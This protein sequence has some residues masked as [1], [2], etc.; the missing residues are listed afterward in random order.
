M[1][2]RTVLGLVLIL[3]NFGNVAQAATGLT[4]H[5]RILQSN[6]SPLTSANVFF[7]IQIR[8]PGAEDCLLYDESQTLNMSGS[9]GVFVLTIGSGTRVAAGVDGG[10]PMERVFANRGTLTVPTC[11]FGVSYTPNIADG[12]ELVVQFSDNGGPWQALPTQNI[13]FVPMAI[14]AMQVGGYEKD[15]LL[16]VADGTVATE[17]SNANW[18]E[19]WDLITGAS[20]VY[21][22]A[23][24]SNF[25]PTA[26]VDFNGQKIIDLADPTLA[27]DAATKNYSDTKIGGKDIDVSTVTNLAGNGHVL[28]WDQAQNRWE[29]GLPNDSTKL[30]LAGGTMTGPIN[31]GAFSVT[32]VGHVVI[33]DQGTM[34]LGKFS[35]GQEAALLLTPLNNT[36][37]RGRTWFNVDTGKMRYWDGLAAQDVA[38]KD[39]VDTAVA[40]ATD[41]SKLPL[42]GGTMAGN[43]VMGGNSIT[44]LAAPAGANDAVR[45]VYADSNLLGLALAAPG[46]GE[47]LK[48]VRWN[49]AGNAWEYFT[50]FTAADLTQAN[51]LAALTYTPVD[52]A[53]DTMTGLLLLS[54]DPSNAVGAATKQ[55]VDAVATAA[56]G[57]YV[58]IDGTTSLTADWDLNGLTVG[59]TRLITG[60]DTPVV[61]DGAANK[62]YVDARE[63]AAVVAANNYTDTEV[64]TAVA[65]GETYADASSAAAQA[66]AQTY[67]DGKLVTKDLAVPAAAQDGQSIRW[68]DTTG[69][70]EYFTASVSTGTVSTVTSANT[71]IAITNNTTTPEL[72]LNVG[73]GNNQIVKLNG[74]AELPAVSGVNLTAL[75]ASNIASG[76]LADARLSANVALTSYVDAGDLQLVTKDLAIPVAG[77]DGQSIRWN[78]TSGDWEYFTPNSGDGSALTNLDADNIASGTLA[79]ARL[80]ANVAL[81]TYVDAGDLQL[82]TKDLAI[83]VVGQDGQSIRWNNTSGDWEYFTINS[84]DGSALTNLDADNIASGTL[85]D[86]RLS[87]NVALKSY[88]DAGDLQLVTKD[89]AIPAAGQD[90]QSIRWNDTSGDWEYFTASVSTGTVSTV[91][92]AN[93]DATITNNTTTPE[94]TI[95]TG[96]GNNQIVKLNGSAELP[97]VSGVNLTALN[98]SNIASGTLN[99]ARLSAN[100][101]LTSYVDTAEADAVTAANAYSDGKLVSKDLAIPA[102]GQDGQSI[103]WND[104]SGDWEYFTAGTGNGTVSTVTSANADIGITNNTTIPELTLNVGTGNNQIVKLNGSAELPAVSGVNLTNLNASNLASGT[105]P[106]ARLSANVAM[107][108]YVD[109]KLVTKDLAVPAAGQDGQSIRW[110]NTSGDWEYFT[111]GSGSGTVST[112]TSANGDATITNNTTTPEITINTGTGNN[113][114]VKL[115]GSAELPAVSGVNLTALNA[116]NIASGTIADARLSANVALTSYVDAGDLRLV[117]KDLAIPAAGQDGQS[118]RWNDTS[119][120]WEYFTAGTGNGT[121]STVTS[122]NADIG[123]TNNTTIPEL[124]LN[125]GTGN[126]QIVK[127]NGSA[128][129]PA[130]SGV[131]L[132]NLNASNLASGT[133]PDARLSANVALTSYVD[134][135]EADAVTAAN[136]YSDGK[137]VS[138]D[139]AVPAAGQDGQSIRWNNTSGD[140]EYFTA[141][142]GSGT[143]STVTSANGDATITNNT[144]T[145]EITIN[146]G[147]GNNQIVKLNGSAELPAVSGVN[148]TALNASNIASGTLNDARLSAN[149]AL[150]SYVDAGDLQLVT[151]DLAIPAAGQDGQSIRWNDTSGDWEYFTAGTGNGTV[152]TVT[153]ANADIGITNN[154][155][156]PELTL[157]V[158]T[159]NNQIVKLN[160][161]A[162]LPAV[163]GVNLTALNA[164][165]IASGTLADARLS[166]NVALTSYVD[167]KL[168]TKDL[169]VPAAGQDGQSIRWNNTSGD[170]EYFTAGSGSGTVSTVTSANG[171]ATIT[172]NTTT[173]EITINTGTG[174][175]QIVKLDGS[176]RLP[177]VDASQLTA[178][179]A[180]NIASGT[181]ADARLSANV[182]LTSYVDAGDLKLVTKDLAIPAAGQDG[183]SIR[184]NN[185]SG[186]WE[187]FAA[188][189]GNGTVSTVTSANA[190]I[191]ITNNTTIPELTLNV[192]TGNNQIVK[193]NGSAELPAVSGVNLTALNASNIASG[194]IADARLSANVA[195]ASYV[196][197]KLVTK[198]L[199]V[200]AAGQDGQSIRWN[201]TSGDWEYFTAGSGSGTVS[202]VTSANG[203][204][205]ITNN[206]TIPE[207]TINT[208]TG[209]NQIV[210]LNGSAELP[211]VSGVNLTALNASNIASGTLADARLSANVALKSYVDAGDLQL[212][213]KDLAIPAAGQDGQSIRWNNTSGDWEYFAAGTGNGTVSTVTSANADIGITNNTT[214]PELTLNVGTGNNQIVKLNGSAELPAVSGVNLTALNASN[215]AS[216]TIADARLSANVALKTYVDAGDLQLVT[217]D[218][219]VP[220]AGQDGQSIRWNN[221]SGDWEY[222]TAGSGSG[223]VSTVTSANGDATITNNTTIPEITI[224]T[225]TGN[226][227]IV[228]LNGSAELPAVSGVNLTALN[229]SN[230]ASG[231]LADA[232]LSANV[233]LKAYTDANILGLPLAAPAAGQV[234]QSIRWNAGNT[235]WEYYTPTTSIA[236]DSLN[237]T[238]F[239]DTLALDA[240]TSITAPNGQAYALSVVNE[241][242]GNSLFVGDEAAD[243]SPFV[244]DASGNVGI[245][246]ASPSAKLDV[247]SSGAGAVQTLALRA[248]PGSAGAGNY[249]SIVFD[250][251]FGA[252]NKKNQFVLASNGAAQFALG[253][254]VSGNGGDNFFLWHAATATHPLYV[255]STGNVGIGSTSANAKLDVKG[256]LG[257][258]GST[259]GIVTFAAPATV[260]SGTYVWPAAMPGS[261]MVLQSDNTGA[262]SW[263]AAAASGLPAADGSAGTPGINFTSD[264]NTGIYR[265]G[266]DSMGFSTGGSQ[267]LLIDDNSVVASVGYQNGLVVNSGGAGYG[268]VA[269]TSPNGEGGRIRFADGQ[270]SFAWDT[271]ISRPSAGKLL[272]DNNAGGAATLEVKGTMSIAGTTSGAVQFAVPAVAGSATY[273]WP[274]AAPGSNMILQSDNTGTLSWVA[275]GAAIADDS[276]DFAKF[277]DAMTLDATTTIT[278]PSG[279]A[280]SMLISNEGTGDSFRVNDANGDTTP[281]IIDAAGNVGIGTAS[282]AKRLELVAPAADLNA[283]MR[284]T[285]GD[286]TNNSSA[287]IEFMDNSGNNRGHLSVS[288]SGNMFLN[289]G[290]SF[291]ISPGTTGSAVNQGFVRFTVNSNGDVITGGGSANDRF[292]VHQIAAANS[293]AAFTSNASGSTA[294][295]GV[296]VGLDSSG[297]A[298]FMNKENAPMI[299]GTNDTE[300]MRISSTGNVGIGTDTTPDAKLDVEGTLGLSGST[301]GIITFAAPATVTSGTY[302]WP[303]AMPGSNMVLQSS[304]TGALSWVAA[305]GAGDF[306]AN[307][308]VPMTGAITVIAGTAAAPGVVFNND[309]D[310]GFNSP[311]AGNVHLS[312]NGSDIIK[313]GHQY[314]GFFNAGGI[315]TA[316][317]NAEALPT[318]S[319]AGDEDTGMYKPAANEIGFSTNAG[320]RLRIDATG[321]VGIGDLSPD[322][323]LDVNGTLGLS[324]ATSGTLTFAAPATVTS[325][326]Y[327][328]P[329]AMPGSNMLLQ[330]DNTGALSWVAAGGVGDFLANGTVPMTAPLQASTGSAAA[331]SLT[332]DGDEDTGFYNYTANGVSLATNGTERVRFGNNGSITAQTA[333]Y[334]LGASNTAASPVYSFASDSNTGMYQ[335]A[336]DTLGFSTNSAERMRVGNSGVDIGTSTAPALLTL[337]SDNTTSDGLRFE[338]SV[339]TAARMLMYNTGTNS[340]GMR[341][342]NSS[343]SLIFENSAGDEEMRLSSTG[344]LGI[345]TST[346]DAKLHIFNEGSTVGDLWVTAVGDNV[347]IHGRRARGTTA[348]PTAVQT[349]DLLTSFGSYARYAADYSLNPVGTFNILAAENHTSTAQGSYLT[350]ETTNIGANSKTEKM[351]ISDSGNV[352]IGD[353]S[354]DALLDIQGTL[355]LSGATSGI[356]TFAA[357]ATVTSGTYVWPAA[358][359]GSNM[360]LQSDNTGALSWVAGGG[361]VAADS[362]NFTDFSDTLALDASTSITA[363]SGQAY[364][365]SVVNEGTGNSFFVGDQATDATPFVIDA[366]GNVGIG[367]SAPSSKFQVSETVTA[368]SGLVRG[369]Y[370][371][372]SVAPSADSTAIVSGFENRVT[373]S[374]AFDVDKA[375]GVNSIVFINGS[376]G[377]DVNSAT[378]VLGQ[379][380]KVNG[381]AGSLSDGIGGSFR[382]SNESATTVTDATGVTAAISQS[383]N[384]G[385]ISGATALNATVT[386]GATSTITSAEGVNISLVNSGTVSSFKGLNLDTIPQTNANYYAIYSNGA[387]KSYF[388][389]SVGIGTSTPGEKLEVSGNVK[390]TSFISTSDERLKDNVHPT[391]GLDIILKLTGVDWTWKSDGKHDA[392]VI[393]QNVEEVMPHAVVTDAASGMKA[394]KYNSLIAP[395]IQSTKELYGMCSASEK[396]NA[397]QDRQIASIAEDNASLKA[398]NIKLRKEVESLNERMERLEALLLN[399]KK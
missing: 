247:S 23:D 153:S 9:N 79:D 196:D 142:S 219:A 48:S 269:I 109:G 296:R 268:L 393:A 397:A 82:V 125:V 71:D 302:V 230:I 192:G 64:A 286:A 201:N 141:G 399:D 20:T 200:P 322:A 237:F 51:V 325:G 385:T 380:T 312:R 72:T 236:A 381:S 214:I 372:V 243:A 140:W 215:I 85:N 217:K 273:T 130:V 291:N 284:L 162:E 80:S 281:F 193:L 205:T 242:T 42:L 290:N 5:G 154:T 244:I 356:I 19:L 145:P 248:N 332:F 10:H 16:R 233:A 124:T 35:A 186:D 299:F 347:G 174:N 262:L 156:I 18:T 25:A 225:G 15:Q 374:T 317:A 53:G 287:G 179:N 373:T 128:E 311:A 326:T 319:W 272:I 293:F 67:A 187:Y 238:D 292:N 37:D 90:G 282:P 151:K 61:A 257:L 350:F 52:K 171:D 93:G 220:A 340:F 213:T 39:Y 366:A 43:I 354:P 283:T 278:A 327:V 352:G 300:N 2:L 24:G 165:N 110:N 95:N 146:T 58:R 241:G 96:T 305:G 359:P 65:D 349:D 129:L 138:K 378:G 86:A 351:R 308:T 363:P 150:T 117:T 76:T 104:T 396:V 50:P 323:K 368:T 178:I 87:A 232:R 191:G 21:Q 99:D 329:A 218:L 389:G 371:P 216:G 234:G 313:L 258:S 101:A 83:P 260:T 68:N 211:A 164:S 127:L 239:S 207:I 45:K 131:N 163:S 132:T 226:N 29:T 249:N 11:T 190:D 31:L 152:S 253:N 328:W 89:L 46:A 246:L 228:K 147:T 227:Q 112:V 264:T 32:N 26:S 119:G 251:T 27:Q 73:T 149:V 229:A 276:L 360:V 47:V 289:A 277:I 167:G 121:V 55:Y 362:L 198:D 266:A 298:V 91:T 172:N 240:S 3:L 384:G 170:W 75:N 100:V 166:A 155:T 370:S 285:S 54:A 255:N 168:V 310:S 330:S 28:L 338:S 135:A 386:N 108:S 348:S 274:A 343:S 97:A 33:A 158:G 30:P 395:L 267:R 355:G 304:N 14:E 320:E 176:S 331:P 334:L 188:G 357:P 223:T 202:T 4:F 62:A 17:L 315:V 118:I 342:L 38:T 102:A 107:T 105:V 335:I 221:T 143:V 120:D 185:T 365:L 367:T 321:N 306:L 388:A 324:G 12:R 199:A 180:S 318:F 309:A 197:G 60:L 206:T 250:N 169:A 344:N 123:I 1:T 333:Y 294:T 222:F 235:A 224:N 194:T 126:N 280:Y 361:G 136:A 212:V 7:H 106:D 36:T 56:A 203:D 34:Y 78:N 113:Q 337:T 275:D 270:S 134:T 314:M 173:P 252:G 111:A 316:T 261:N 175:N 303:A 88:V 387:A 63:A 144:T 84:G 346:P 271:A 66:A 103:R 353:T 341:K 181:I 177:A 114:I 6:N 40:G 358:M 116:S 295:D 265:P 184:W 379:A 209:N 345:G 377:A 382:F 74:S 376:A 339:G 204:A 288:G 98:A 183:Q 210:K 81:K 137:L 375:Q 254:D 369:I 94:I 57:A 364:V 398:E 59:G 394:V 77:Q 182:A 41:A 115:N 256:T 159:G 208:G 49:A 336:A 231:T 8:S 392:G 13:N 139:L 69:D 22:K 383:A 92:S 44:G 259:S 297:N 148:L 157:N 263:V 122:A 307:G 70:W 301:S 279:Q 390:A 391:A 189:T 133:V 160:G 161:S 245:G 195:L